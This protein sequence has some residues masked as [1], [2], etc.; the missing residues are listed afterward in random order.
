MKKTYT[1][2]AY[3]TIAILM[4]GVVVYGYMKGCGRISAGEETVELIKVESVGDIVNVTHGMM[5][6]EETECDTMMLGKLQHVT[7]KSW[8]RVYTMEPTGDGYFWGREWNTADDIYEE[9][10]LTYGNG[11]FKWK[12]EG[13]NVVEIHMTD[14]HIAMIP[15]EYKVLLLTD[16]EMKYEEAADA[17]KQQFTKCID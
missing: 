3:L 7:E 17:D 8:Y 12:K 16:N 5:V 6:F 1:I 15:L 10:L 11:W 2:F 9:D 4:M 13:E 14:S